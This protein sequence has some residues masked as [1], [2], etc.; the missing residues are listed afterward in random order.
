VALLW[1]VAALLQAPHFGLAGS[2]GAGYSS[3]AIRVTL[4]GTVFWYAAL[5]VGHI[6]S[7][8]L[9]SRAFWARPCDPQCYNVWLRLQGDTER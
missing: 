7:R 2:A 9:H 6:T 4:P 1:A 5:L 3:S 8:P